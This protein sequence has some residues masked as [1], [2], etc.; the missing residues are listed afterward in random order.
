ME[1]SPIV[2]DSSF[3]SAIRSNGFDLLLVLLDLLWL[4]DFLVA[5]HLTPITSSA[6]KD[7]ICWA[8][9][10]REINA[11]DCRIKSTTGARRICNTWNAASTKAAWLFQVFAGTT[12]KG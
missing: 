10:N 11:L 2:I 5:I 3:S 4:P 9:L 12:H 8:K 6:I 1:Y 7:I